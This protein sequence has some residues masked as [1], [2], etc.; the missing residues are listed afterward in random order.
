M[1][2]LLKQLVNERAALASV[3]HEDLLIKVDDDTRTSFQQTL[4]S[5]YKDILAV[6]EKY[7]ITPFLIGGSALGAVRHKGFIP[8]DD[9][10][11]IG[12]LRDDYRI[13]ISVFDSELSDRYSINAP[14]I[15][16]N[17]RNRF[18]KIYKKTEADNSQGENQSPLEMCID[19]FIIE[20]IPKNKLIRAV[21][22]TYCNLLQI[23]AS[24]VYF[25]ENDNPKRRKKYLRLG[26]SYYSTRYAIGK[27]F[28]FN[29]SSKWFDKV[30]KAAQ[31]DRHTGLYAMVTARTHYFGEI[32]GEDD[33]FPVRYV[34]FCDIKAPVLN[35]TDAYL[36]KLYGDYMKLPPEHE[37]ERHHFR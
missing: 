23:I 27:L 32:L 36:K 6:C 12:M 11:D 37:R 1:I 29:S 17:S 15:T 7:S 4:L 31:Y 25:Y 28:S 8:W 26:K 20:N 3:E 18:T 9:D 35:N 13:F 10:L 21:K 22:G 14:N 19:L 24:Q 2:K 5:I 30:D 34:D 16:S 33:Y